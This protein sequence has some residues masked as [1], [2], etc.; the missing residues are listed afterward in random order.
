MNYR[1]EMLEVQ[2]IKF[3]HLN[4]QIYYLLMLNIRDINSIFNIFISSYITILIAYDLSR[5]TF[6]FLQYAIYVR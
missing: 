1:K 4:R 5:I 3:D 2:K 6:N